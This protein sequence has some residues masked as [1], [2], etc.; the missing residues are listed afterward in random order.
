MS[1]ASR[2][3]VACIGEEAVSPCCGKRSTLGWNAQVEPNRHLFPHF[4]TSI[5]LWVPSK[6][7]HVLESG[8][9]LR[10]RATDGS[11]E[12]GRAENIRH[13]GWCGVDEI[14]AKTMDSI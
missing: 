7:D 8:E 13:S 12:H 5:R 10:H 14:S 2:T 3:Y 9:Q 11:L 1:A 6:A 4:S